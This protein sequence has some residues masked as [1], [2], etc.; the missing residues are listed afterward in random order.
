MMI[1]MILIKKKDTFREDRNKYLMAK[2]DC[3]EEGDEVNDEI[4][5]FYGGLQKEFKKHLKKIVLLSK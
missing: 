3:E 1:M 2:K 4:Y 5:D